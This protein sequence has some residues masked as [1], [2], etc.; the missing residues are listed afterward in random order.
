MRQIWRQ[1][2]PECLKHDSKAI[3]DMVLD[4]ETNLCLQPLVPLKAKVLPS[5]QYQLSISRSV[6]VY[7]R[8]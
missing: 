5:P 3:I 2:H 6:R 8:R 4:D 1:V 7:T